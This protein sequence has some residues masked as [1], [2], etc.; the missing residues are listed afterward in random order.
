MEANDGRETC[1]MMAASDTG[2]DWNN[3]ILKLLYRRWSLAVKAVLKQ[4]CD[5]I[6]STDRMCWPLTR[7]E[8]AGK[9]PHPV[10]IQEP[11]FAL[12]SV[13]VQIP[14]N[15]L[16][17]FRS[18][19]FQ[20]TEPLV[21][22]QSYLPFLSLHSRAV[23]RHCCSR[24][25]R[26]MMSPVTWHAVASWYITCSVA[27]DCNARY[28]WWW[29]LRWFCRTQP[30]YF[31]SILTIQSYKIHTHTH[32]LPPLPLFFKRLFNKKASTPRNKG[33]KTISPSFPIQ[34]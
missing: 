3:L 1:F 29:D 22:A 14:P 13:T 30:L 4:T 7:R 9:G 21:C 32:S 23:F 24:V 27:K 10:A 31:F 6:K 33:L 25:R 17:S 2:R 8:K 15:M 26:S 18:F 11:T 5:K 16:K 20:Q 12:A 19:S 34:A 28:S